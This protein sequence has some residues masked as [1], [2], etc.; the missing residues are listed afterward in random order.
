MLCLYFYT[1]IIGHK[2]RSKLFLLIELQNFM[3]NNVYWTRK[4]KNTTTTKQKMKQK[5]LVRAGTSRTVVCFMTSKHTGFTAKVC[6]TSVSGTSNMQL[7][8]VNGTK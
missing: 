5:I 8:L 4:S 7:P 1:L 2:I 3:T 6:L